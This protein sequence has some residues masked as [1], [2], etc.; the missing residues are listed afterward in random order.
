M[1]SFWSSVGSSAMANATNAQQQWQS[2]LSN[3][4]K[5]TSKESQPKLP[6]VLCVFVHGF[7]GS[8][9]SF[10]HFPKDLS[11][12]I[13]HTS[14]TP[15][16]QYVLQT[17]HFAYDTQGDN[18]VVVEK[19][20]SFLID[21]AS[22]SASST[23]PGRQVILLAH[24]MGG[25][26][27]VDAARKIHEMAKGDVSQ[28]AVHIRGIISFDSPFFG[29]HPN[30][31]SVAGSGRM[32]GAL[33]DATGMLGMIGKL[34][35]ENTGSARGSASSKST[36]PKG[37]ES[38]SSGSSGSYWNAAIGAAALAGVAY[39]AY[40]SS[41]VVKQA[42]DRTVSDNAGKVTQYMQFLGPLWRVGDQK[43]RFEDVQSFKWLFFRGIFLSLAKENSS[44]EHTFTQ[45]TQV[46]D[47]VPLFSKHTMTTSTDVIDAHMNMFNEKHDHVAYM[48]LLQ[49]ASEHMCQCLEHK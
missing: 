32:Q 43:K 21:E 23:E 2:L 35:N 28:H 37:A 26:L 1:S 30:T 46:G 14:T 47:L 9:D 41:A 5:P 19:L 45:L 18:A 36:L 10:H 25:P 39:T 13:A 4:A 22:S 3:A 44:G 20:V 38:G 49:Q 31:L 27:S 40:S 42:V 17:K 29:L 16:P 15:Q 8:N 6:V 12:A 11:T 7:M 33:N 48:R 24:S 34:A